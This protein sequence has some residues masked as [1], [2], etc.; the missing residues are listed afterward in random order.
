MMRVGAGLLLGGAACCFAPAGARAFSDLER[1][2]MPSMEGGG[3]GRFFTGSPIDGYACGVCHQGGQEPNVIVYGL[4]IEGYVPGQTYDVEIAWDNP[5]LYHS[6]HLEFIDPVGRGPAGGLALLG[7]T[8]ADAA[9][10]CGLKP[11]EEVAEFFYTG[12]GRQILGVEA[13]GAAHL[14]FR[15]TAPDLPEVVFAGS[16]VRSNSSVSPDGDGVHNLNRVL[17]RVGEPNQATSKCSFGAADARDGGL[18]WGLLGL[19]AALLARR[20]RRR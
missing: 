7:K 2:S 12:D 18:A 10:R 6:L 8:L 14:R 19:L 20:A 9:S 1:Y 3:G 16:V 17:R 13:C 4:P 15:F 11:D 5:Q